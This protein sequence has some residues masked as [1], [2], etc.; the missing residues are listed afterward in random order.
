MLT[1]AVESVTGVSL[2][3][4]ARVAALGVGAG[5]VR[6]ALVLAGAALVVL[7]AVQPV[8]P[9]VAGQTL[10]LVRAQGVFAHG[11]GAAVVARQT[12]LFAALVHV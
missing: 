11:V 5:G 8:H 2:V 10:A 6:V 4:V 7:F 12:A 1:F 9:F 3:A